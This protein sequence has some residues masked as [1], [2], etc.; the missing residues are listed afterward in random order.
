MGIIKI[1]LHREW[2][3][4]Y[5]LSNTSMAKCEGLL[6]FVFGLALWDSLLCCSSGWLGIHCVA[7]VDS[8]TQ[9]TFCL[10]VSH[11]AW[12]NRNYSSHKYC[13]LIGHR[14]GQDRGVACGLYCSHLEGSSSSSKFLPLTL[15]FFKSWMFRGKGRICLFLFKRHGLG[16]LP[17][18][19]LNWINNPPVWALSRIATMSR[20]GKK[21]CFL[22]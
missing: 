11:H 9:G 6:G 14:W 7:W 16:F 22:F 8:Y 4:K 12:I 21:S 2:D 13:V 10:S 17:R 3:N 1:L 20:W 18:F 5:E 15:R 19:L